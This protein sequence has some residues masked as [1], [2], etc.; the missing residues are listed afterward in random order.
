VG[1]VL[2]WGDC[3]ERARHAACG[4]FSKFRGLLWR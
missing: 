1:A 4:S 2:S 3:W